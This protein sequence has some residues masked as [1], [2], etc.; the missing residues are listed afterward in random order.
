MQSPFQD[1]KGTY[2]KGA[3]TMKFCRWGE[4]SGSTPNMARKSGNLLPINQVG[5]GESGVDEWS[6]I[7]RKHQG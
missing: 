2:S 1:G 4:K 6:V 7:K 5:M 3:A